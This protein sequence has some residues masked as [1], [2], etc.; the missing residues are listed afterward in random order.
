MV[1]ATQGIFGLKKKLLSNYFKECPELVE[2]INNKKMKSVEDVLT[3]Y[4]TW[5]EENL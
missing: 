3:F 2:K 4:N 5:Y 1:R